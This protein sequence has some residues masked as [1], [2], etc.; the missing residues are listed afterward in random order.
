MSARFVTFWLLGAYLACTPARAD[1][2]NPAFLQ[3][4][5]TSPDHFAVTL[6]LPLRGQ[7]PP[8]VELL[9]PDRVATVGSVRRREIAGYLVETRSVHAAGG[10]AGS[11]LAFRGLGGSATDVIARVLFIDGSEQVE[12]LEAGADAFTVRGRRGTL[13]V[14]AA[15]FALGVEHILLGP[16]HLLFVLALLLL[17]DGWRRILAT[18][19]A[20]TVAHSLTLVAAALGWVR[21]PGAPVEAVIALSI[22]F[23]AA[24][25]L[26]SWRGRPGI[27]ARAPWIVAFA[28][29]LLHGLGF[30]AALNDIGLPEQAILPALLA[31]NLGVEAGQVLFV[32]A[33]LLLA[34]L[35]QR[36]R[37]P[38]RQLV[39]R[40]LL[41]YGI[42]TLAAYWSIE[43][44][45]TGVLGFSL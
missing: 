8:A 25:A 3:L 45:W 6:R 19:T 21:V 18:I 40:T 1:V 10:L 44:V 20:F 4:T 35:A 31:F 23:V 22:V 38:A 14:S 12:R 34:A 43:R 11:R 39:A 24:E 7:Q 13:A 33:M 37:V 42:G 29:G 41:P 15:Y 17:V 28:F 9:F 16:D 26:H 36:S 30:A 27:T 32:A 5:E 2:F